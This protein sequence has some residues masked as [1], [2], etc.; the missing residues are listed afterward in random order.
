MNVYLSEKIKVLSFAAIILIV[1][2]HANNLFS[3]HIHFNLAGW[4][5]FIEYFVS[6]GICRIA[7]PLFFTI[8]GFLFF[9]NLNGEIAGYLA[10]YK[11][12]FFTLCIPFLLWS[13][14]GL[15]IFILLQNLP[16]S[17]VFF[18]SKPI[19]L[20][21]WHEALRA[22]FI[23][24]I[25]YQLWFLQDL[26]LLVVLS[27]LVSFLLQKTKGIILIVFGILWI[28]SFQFPFLFIESLF[29]F[30]LGSFLSKKWILE[31]QINIHDKLLFLMGLCWILSLIVR[32]QLLI[33]SIFFEW[34]VILN[35]ISILI[36]L[37]FIWFLYDK[38]AL[39]HKFMLE[40][41][42]LLSYPFFIYAFHEPVLTIFKKG[43]FFLLGPNNNSLIIVYFTAPIITITLSIFIGMI[44]KSNL[45][46]L[47]SLSVGNR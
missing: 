38:L 14:W 29:F 2:L 30:S 43:L 11:S 22:I 3:Y 35:K 7:V 4:V 44:L 9:R 45:P 31:K 47:Y 1:F 5:F 42:N 46:K 41:K 20:Y 10:K 28:D 26:I 27:P 25:P 15:F 33:F 12:R 16:Y 19:L 34:V 40:H 8:S 6:D 37:P 23:T 32:S 18:N 39:K 13:L 21:N 17:K 24:P 36:G